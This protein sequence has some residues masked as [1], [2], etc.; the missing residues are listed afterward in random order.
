VKRVCV[1]NG[2]SCEGAVKVKAAEPVRRP[3]SIPIAQDIVDARVA[4]E[5]HKHP[6]R[7]RERKA[8]EKEVRELITPHWHKG[9]IEL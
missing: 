5:I 8:V 2:Y 7:K 6:E 9:G 1:E 4:E 3:K